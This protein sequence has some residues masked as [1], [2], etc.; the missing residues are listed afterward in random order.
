MTFSCQGI[1]DVS[2]TV[3]DVYGT[4]TKTISNMF[5]ILND[6]NDNE[7]PYKALNVYGSGDYIHFDNED[8]T[9]NNF[10]RFRLGKTT[11]NSG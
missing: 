3:T 1:Y 11:G 4:D 2:L 7:D 8:W 6:C 9:L 5:V 10:Y